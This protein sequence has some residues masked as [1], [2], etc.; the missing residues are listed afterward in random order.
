MATLDGT[1]HEVLILQEKNKKSEFW[2][3]LPVSFAR[4]KNLKRVV[5]LS[6]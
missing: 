1:P 6:P 2:F 4:M 3:R 5:L